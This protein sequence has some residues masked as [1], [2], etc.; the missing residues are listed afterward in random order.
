MVSHESL[1]EKAYP[2]Y[3]VPKSI[4]ATN[5]NGGLGFLLG[6]FDESMLIKPE[7]QNR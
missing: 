3:V 1:E 6:S 7:L 4:A 2:E 5:K